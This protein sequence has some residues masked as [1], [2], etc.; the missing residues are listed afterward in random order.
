MSST[1]RFDGVATEYADTWGPEFIARYLRKY[2]HRHTEAVSASEASNAVKLAGTP[3]GGRVLDCPCGYGRHARPLARLGYQVTGADR[4]TLMLERAERESA[5]RER[6]GA[7][8]VRWVE[9]DYRQLPFADGSFDTVL[10]MFTSF[11][12]C[13]D[14]QDTAVLAEY[15]RVLRP[16][17]TL[18]IDTTHRDR[19]VRSFEPEEAVTAGRDRSS[20]DIRTGWLEMIHTDDADGTGGQPTVS[21]IRIYTVT[22]LTTMLAAAGFGRVQVYGALDG[23][24]LTWDTRMITVA[25]R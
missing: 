20:F 8:R 19:L 13:G 5:E 7:G 18:L 15:R 11:G 1:A 3:A 21:Q 6:A 23:S 10:N 4:S 16:G 12:Y 2:E 24:P 14:E 22:E 17:G 25:T 9:S